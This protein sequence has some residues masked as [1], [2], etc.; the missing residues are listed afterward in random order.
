MGDDPVREPQCLGF[1]WER[2]AIGLVTTVSHS[3]L[4]QSL[5][6]LGGTLGCLPP[7]EQARTAVH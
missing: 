7:N 1:T 2:S 5:R 3:T 6:F 4:N